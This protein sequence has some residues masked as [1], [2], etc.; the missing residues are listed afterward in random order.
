MNL[1]PETP[2]ILLTFHESMTRGFDASE[3]GADAVVRKDRDMF[4]LK[5]SV[6]VLLKCRH[7]SVRQNN[8]PKKKS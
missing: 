5:E 1:L 2:I 3:I 6:K 4:P 7:L 8:G